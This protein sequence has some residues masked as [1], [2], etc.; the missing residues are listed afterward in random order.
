MAGVDRTANTPPCSV[1]LSRDAGYAE[2]ACLAPEV[3]AE[4]G[5]AQVIWFQS[6]LPWVGDAQLLSWTVPSGQENQRLSR[7]GD[8]VQ[9]PEVARSS[10]ELQQNWAVPS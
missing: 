7:G 8:G 9:P 6:S 10:A 1:L 4:G 3:C 2:G 5:V